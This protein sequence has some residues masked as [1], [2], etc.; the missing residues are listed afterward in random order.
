M[1]ESARR[2]LVFVP[3]LACSSLALAQA[4]VAVAP[5]GPVS[6]EGTGLAEL[7]RRLGNAAPTGAGVTLG[8]VEAG[9]PAWLPDGRRA[10]LAHLA[11][12]ALPPSEPSSAHASL[13]LE[14]LCG[15]EGMASGASRVLA[16]EASHWLGLGFLNGSGPTA[17]VTT[18]AK[19]LNHSWIG[20][21]ERANVV[22]RKLDA[23]IDAQG[24]VVCVGV[25]NGQG[26]LD[27]P[28][29]AHSF[30]TIVCGRADG[31]HRSGPTRPGCDRPGREKPDL[32]APAEATSFAT[33]LVAGACALLVETA[34]TRF[35]G[36]ADAERPELIKAVLMAGAAHR[37][38]W[39]NFAPN[40]GP[41]RGST[42][43]PLDALWGADTLDVD[44]AHWILA[45][46]EQEGAPQ[47]QRAPQLSS[48]GWEL[49]PV[50][51]QTSRF[52]RLRVDARS[53]S[54][55]IVAA[56]NRQA[57]GNFT[58]W[59]LPN[60][61]LELWR[62]GADGERES[63]VGEAARAHFESGNVASASLIDNVEHLF[64]RG[65]APG[66]Y[67]LELRRGADGLVPWK[68]AVA[69]ELRCEE[70]QVLGQGSLTL[71]GEPATL[72]FR[73][74]ASLSEGGFVLEA[75]GGRPG[76]LAVLFASASGAT[77]TAE[78][79]T[80]LAGE[81]ERIA[82]VALDE[83]GEVDLPLELAAGAN[84]AGSE[85]WYQLAILAPHSA[86]GFALTNALRAR[87]CR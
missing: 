82:T 46:G 63:L 28:L 53:E 62:V 3:L 26:P 79:V 41:L 8:E 10:S 23:A 15:A 19:V 85:C 22:L 77:T 56:W 50:A 83:R 24:L 60:F 33:P 5:F 72:S 65:L 21:S 61:D 14:Y 38:D 9:V 58:G 57:Y 76:A 6:V 84:E 30:N 16:F 1:V 13:V 49:S 59:G 25:N 69:W 45:G 74:R 78:G 81:L 43:R 39:S 64:V 36:Q 75:R 44:H 48:Q 70:P 87:L 55:S 34:R 31:E 4:P 73:G 80:R 68:V 32:V 37:P 71:S 20:A 86:G 29:L 42:T 35:P 66:E 7:R 67:V 2:C 27:A 12:E 18:A 40:S 54:L 17:P 52:W 11:I 51:A 47:V